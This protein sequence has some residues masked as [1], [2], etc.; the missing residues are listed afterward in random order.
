M[1]SK[2][3]YEYECAFAQ[4]FN[5]QM[6]FQHFALSNGWI[7]ESYFAPLHFSLL[8]MFALPQNT[9]FERDSIRFRPIRQ[10]DQGCVCTVYRGAWSL[11]ES[12]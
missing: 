5:L 3:Q 2:C 8:D 9:A 7:K 4:K 6:R 10:N 1:R 12:V 11:G